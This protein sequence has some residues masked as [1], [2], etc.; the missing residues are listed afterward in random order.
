VTSRLHT[1][2]KGIDSALSRAFRVVG[3]RRA[4]SVVARG[5]DRS[6]SWLFIVK[7]VIALGF[8]LVA[9][10]F[11]TY[12]AQPGEAIS[13]AAYLGTIGTLYSVLVAFLVV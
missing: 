9:Q 2:N 5:H 11:D 1:V 12:F 4:A 13:V 6:F 7:V 8:G 3:L 10:N